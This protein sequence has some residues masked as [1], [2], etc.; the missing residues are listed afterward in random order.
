MEPLDQSL[1]PLRHRF[2]L[3]RAGKGP[4]SGLTPVRDGFSRSARPRHNAALTLRV[5]VHHLGE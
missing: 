2:R 4:R 5:A 1:L 3:C